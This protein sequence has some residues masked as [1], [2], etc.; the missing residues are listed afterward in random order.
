M[1]AAAQETWRSWAGST[2]DAYDVEQLTATWAGRMGDAAVLTVVAVDGAGEV[3]AVG[4]VCPEA[5]SYQPSRADAA[6]AH[7]STL[8]AHP[9]V[10]GRG[11][12]Q[13]V[14]DELLAA[15]AE[16]GYT[17]IRLWVAA[18][19]AQARRFYERNGW[20]LTGNGI[21]F[22]GLDRVEYRLPL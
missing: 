22:A 11:I 12:A 8:F 6:S 2:L 18:G 14:H 5:S 19:A 21:M 15:A 4:S 13:Q 1:I 9:S 3:L 16:S 17:T 10:H 7:L 20:N